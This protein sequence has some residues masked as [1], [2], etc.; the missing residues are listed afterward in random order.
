MKS[1]LKTSNSRNKLPKKITKQNTKKI[2]LKTIKIKPRDTHHNKLITNFLKFFFN[3]FYSVFSDNGQ[4]FLKPI[5]WLAILN[6]IFYKLYWSVFLIKKNCA[7]ILSFV[8]TINPLYNPIFL[9][10]IPEHIKTNNSFLRISCL[11]MLINFI[12]IYLI[13]LVVYKKYSKTT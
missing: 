13:L 11:Q 10:C 4:S 3:I 1:K 6:F 7:L 8:K 9:S 12:L 5:I 2:L